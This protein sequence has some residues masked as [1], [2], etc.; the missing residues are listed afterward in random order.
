[1]RG[2]I[3]QDTEMGED[4]MVEA[5]GE[6]VVAEVEAGAAGVVVVDEEEGVDVDG[7]RFLFIEF[8][9]ILP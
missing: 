1:M 7:G 2:Q 9:R 6:E 3:H 5:V 4:E 8:N